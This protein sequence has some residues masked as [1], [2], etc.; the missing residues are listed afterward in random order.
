MRETWTAATEYR[1]AVNIETNCGQKL[2]I[3]MI[4]IKVLKNNLCHCFNLIIISQEL[5][6]LMD[7]T[8]YLETISYLTSRKVQFK[9]GLQ[10]RKSCILQNWFHFS[11]NRS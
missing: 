5:F 11:G 3:S 4:L 7:Y 1:Y 10:L 8:D 6:P 9:I 2:K